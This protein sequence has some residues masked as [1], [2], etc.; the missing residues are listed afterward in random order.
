MSH[1][2][3]AASTGA[4]R[5]ISTEDISARTAWRSLPAVFAIALGL[6]ASV[7]WGVGDF[8]GGLQSR[9]MPAVAVVLGSQLAGLALVAVIIAIRGTAPPGGDFLLYA[10]TSSI[11]GIV[12]LTAFYRAL[13]IGSMGVVAPLSSTAA[14]IPLAVGLA[15]GDS[16][17]A[18]QATGIALA[19]AGVVLASRE[20]GDEAKASTAVAR[21]AGLALISAV[22]FGFFFVM[23]AKASDADVMWAVCVNRTVSA[24]LLSAA[25]LVTR[26]PIGL[27]L[28][29]MRILGVI[30]VLD[31]G[32]NGLF[33][34]ASTK[35]LVSVVSVLASLYPIVTVVLARVVLKERL[36]AIQRIG[37]VA[38]LAGVALISAG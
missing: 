10:A 36:H 2:F 37:A 14:I 29:D 34:L 17:N 12:G 21:G 33:A 11:G 15:G 1:A 8:L 18:L 13:S 20:A 5:F 23:I 9:R 26:P 30:G 38:A 24:L 19:I 6:A 3:A 31:T 7:S 16:L 27:K 25:L 22:G 32:A 28:R 35:G 4:S